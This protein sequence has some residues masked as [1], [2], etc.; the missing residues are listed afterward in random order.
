MTDRRANISSCIF[1]KKS[2]KGWAY[3]TTRILEQE[4]KW[5]VFGICSGLF[6]LSMLY[7]ASTAVIAVDLSK[8]LRLSPDDLGILG[9]LYFYA[10]TLMQFPLGQILDR[11]GARRTM[12]LLNVVG[13]TGALVFSQAGGLSAGLVGRGLL[14]LGMS[15]NMV[16]TFVLFTKWFGPREFATVSGLFL[17]LGSCGSLLATSPLRLL[18]DLVGWRQ[19]FLILTAGSL[20]FTAGLAIWIKETPWGDRETHEADSKTVQGRSIIQTLKVLFRD[21]NYWSIAL[22]SCVWY[23]VLATIMNLW[24]GPFLMVHLGLPKLAASN[25][26]LAAGIGGMI[27]SPLGGLLSDRVLK[28]RKNTVLLSLGV[29]AG[30]VLAMAHW[31]GTRWMFLLAALFFGFGCFGGFGAVLYTH[32]KELMPGDMSGTALTGINFFVS[33]GAAV[34]LQIFGTVIGRAGGEGLEAGEAY[35]WAFM[36]CFGSMTAA[37]LVYTFSRD[38]NPAKQE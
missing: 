35:Y 15:V 4:K 12:I 2:A 18:A 34:F 30:S 26:L 22:A 8:D 7:R 27:G 6:V 5:V 16:G 28:S 20:L 3:V 36:I 1:L 33:L 31:P 19:A 23:G 24:G 17:A 11:I 14:G 37:V 25:I 29:M 10:T 9:A 38:T 21:P 13:A 32:I